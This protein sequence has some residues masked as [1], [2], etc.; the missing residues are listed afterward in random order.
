MNY[1]TIFRDS[2]KQL[3]INIYV[4]EKIFIVSANGLDYYGIFDS[5]EDAKKFINNF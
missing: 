4:N 2:V 3:N 5:F 1:I